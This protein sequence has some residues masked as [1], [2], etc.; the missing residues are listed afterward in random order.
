MHRV[1]TWYREGKDVQQLLPSLATYL[2]HV[3]IV[4]TQRYLQM[5]PELLHQASLRFARYAAVEPCEESCDA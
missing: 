4:S 5:T 3:S 2:G 1:V